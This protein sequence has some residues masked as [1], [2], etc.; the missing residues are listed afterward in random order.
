IWHL[1]ES[2]T[3]KLLEFA[4]ISTH[5]KYAGH[6][7]MHNLMMFDLMKQKSDGIQG[8][9]G[10]CTAYNSQRLLAKLGFQVL[11]QINYNEWLDKD[12]KQIFKCDDGT[13][14]AQLVY[15]LY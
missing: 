2:S 11:Y 12:G 7:L 9:I 8:G 10:E 4:I 3:T 13:N 6:G 14:C 15:R 1:V 5:E